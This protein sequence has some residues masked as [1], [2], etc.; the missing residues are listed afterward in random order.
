M[1]NPIHAYIG[2]GSNLGQRL[3]SLQEAVSQLHKSQGLVLGQLSAVY[4]CKP[5]GYES[6]HNY[7]NA[8]LE[9]QFAGPP[10]Q[11]AELCYKIESAGGRHQA[12]ANAPRFFQ[13]R[14]ID[15]DILHIDGVE[16]TDGRLTLPHPRAHQR[17]FVLVPL[18]DIA[19]SL[20][21]RGKTVGQWL[22][23]LSEGE[24]AGVVASSHVL[25]VE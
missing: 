4:D 1:R 3:D 21:L 25:V 15:L 10:L 19:P 23:A 16:T 17:A 13:D 11:L 5:W 18:I 22:E 2:L 6:E 12:G 7:L 24:I 9:C 8:V 14:S 20:V